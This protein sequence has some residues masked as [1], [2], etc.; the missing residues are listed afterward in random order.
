MEAIKQL[1]LSQTAVLVYE[2]LILAVLLVFIMIFTKKRRH[3]KQVQREV[4]ERQAKQL[5]DDS[6]SNQRRRA[7]K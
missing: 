2:L 4:Q 1:L 7:N 6:L 5:L 3:R